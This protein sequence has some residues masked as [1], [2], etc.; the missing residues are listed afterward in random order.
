MYKLFQQWK[1]ELH[2]GFEGVRTFFS[3]IILGGFYFIL[4]IIIL[5]IVFLAFSIVF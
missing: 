1:M 4:V 3:F 2:N 5:A